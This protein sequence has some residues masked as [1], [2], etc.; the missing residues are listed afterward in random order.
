MASR[1]AWTVGGKAVSAD[2]P[3]TL[4]KILRDAKGPDMLTVF[5]IGAAGNVNHIDVRSPAR[6]NGNGEAARIGSVLAAEVLRA[7]P[8]LQPAAVTALHSEEVVR[9]PLPRVAPGDFEGPG[10]AKTRANRHAHHVPRD[11]VDAAHPGR[12]AA[13]RP[14]ARWK[15]R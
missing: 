2:Y 13:R 6:Q 7:Y 12:H 1:C 15:C 11:H 10:T 9:L 14:R 8:K 4:A 3:Y 5:S